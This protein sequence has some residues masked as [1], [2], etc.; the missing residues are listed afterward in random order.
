MSKQYIYGAR[1]IIEAIESQVIIDKIWIDRNKQSSLI[2]E[3]IQLCKEH[4]IPF[5][6]VPEE[7]F[8][9]FKNKNHQGIVAK[10]SLIEF[11][12]IENIIINTYEKGEVPLILILDGISDVRNFG[13]IARTALSSGVHAIII[14]QKGNAQI[15]EDAI[16]T[17]AGALLHI[18]VCREESLK[19]TIDLLRLH[20]I[21]IVACTEKAQQNI[22][23][24]P[25]IGP[26]AFIFGNEEKGISQYLIKTASYL[27]KIPMLGKVSSLNVSVATGIVLYECVRQRNFNNIK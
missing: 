11:Q 20:G 18:P 2:K 7:K 25:L 13:A 9:S 17:S 21:N 14:E 22:Y 8:L 4:K 3:V 10:S 24:I 23:E 26:L 27:V 1:A 16:K 19:K 6:F 15:N 5:Q 12:S